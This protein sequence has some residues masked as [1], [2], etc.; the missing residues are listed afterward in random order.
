MYY[1]GISRLVAVL[2]LASAPPCAQDHQISPGPNY[3]GAK[4]F[5]NASS[6]DTLDLWSGGRL[7][8]SDTGRGR[9]A[10]GPG[11]RRGSPSVL[12]RIPKC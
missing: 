3:S 9:K 6:S 8:C 10:T 1:R 12:M 11:I 5:D 7:N 2:A 4:N